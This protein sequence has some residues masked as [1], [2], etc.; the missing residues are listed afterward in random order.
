[1]L[2]SPSILAGTQSY[3]SGTGARVSDKDVIS[4]VGQNSHGQMTDL[5]AQA[6][7]SDQEPCAEATRPH[8]F[9]IPWTSSRRPQWEKELLSSYKDESDH[10]SIIGYHHRNATCLVTFYWYVCRKS[11]AS[12]MLEPC[13]PF[14]SLVV[15]ISILLIYWYII[16]VPS[17]LQGAWLFTGGFQV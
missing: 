8:I 16:W 9:P 17:W 4:W 10:P 5:A 12:P 14:H 15:S 2:P 11:R 7:I 13:S 3:S 1:M 6:L